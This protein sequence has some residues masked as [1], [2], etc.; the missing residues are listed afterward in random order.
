M[1]GR[2]RDQSLPLNYSCQEVIAL[3]NVSGKISTSLLLGF[4]VPS[5]HWKL[6]PPSSYR[7]LT[8]LSPLLGPSH[9]NFDSWALSSQCCKWPATTILNLSVSS[10]AESTATQLCTAKWPFCRGG[11]LKVGWNASASPVST[12]H[13]LVSLHSP[14]PA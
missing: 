5:A 9:L 13:M 8:T 6:S 12:Q 14:S 11:L 2:G 1:K 7:V 4:Y 10:R 3:A